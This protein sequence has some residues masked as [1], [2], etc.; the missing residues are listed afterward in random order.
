MSGV[1]VC[2]FACVC[3]KVTLRLGVFGVYEVAQALEVVVVV[4]VV[5][6][7]GLGFGLG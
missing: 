3:D 6:G 5:L 2:V 4:V 7:L 1:C